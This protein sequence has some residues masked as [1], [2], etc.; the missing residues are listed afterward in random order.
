M[1]ELKPCPLCGGEADYKTDVDYR[2][3]RVQCLDC[4]CTTSQYL[5]DVLCDNKFGEDWAKER[6]NRRAD[7]AK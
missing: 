6:W 7:N 5:I 4:G 1:P 2:Y 3:I